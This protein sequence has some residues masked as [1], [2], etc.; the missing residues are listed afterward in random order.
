MCL[1][2][3]VQSV[4]GPHCDQTLSVGRGAQRQ[5]RCRGGGWNLSAEQQ[6]LSDGLPGVQNSPCSLH[7][8]RTHSLVCMR[9][10]GPPGPQCSGGGAGGGTQKEA[11]PPTLL[12]LCLQRRAVRLLSDPRPTKRATLWP[13][14]QGLQPPGNHPLSGCVS[15]TLSL[16]F[17]EG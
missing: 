17:S 16:F 10:G 14:V 8:V 2:V 6:S 13:V 4:W 15:I 9:K 3:Q 12:A 1:S 11:P 5:M 7:G